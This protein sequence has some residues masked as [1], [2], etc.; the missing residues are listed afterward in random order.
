MPWGLGSGGWGNSAE[1]PITYLS[2]QL[3]WAVPVP[4]ESLEMHSRAGHGEDNEVGR[5][6]K[7]SGSWG[8]SNHSF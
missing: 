2:F 6:G 5:V 4:T 8:N 7:Q 1:R 3:M